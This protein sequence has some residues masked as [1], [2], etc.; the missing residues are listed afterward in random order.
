MGAT[1]DY[2][3]SIAKKALLTAGNILKDWKAPLYTKWKGRIDPVTIAD[4][5]SEKHIVDILKKEFPN[6]LII[7]EEY[8]PLKEIEVKGKRRWYL[9]PL[10]GT[11]NFFRG[12][13]NWCI[14][15]ALADENDKIVCA[16]VNDPTMNEC[17]TA[18]K[19]NGAYL[20]D[21]KINVS[22]IT[23]LKRSVVASGFPYTFDNPD[24]T[25]LREW[26]NLVPLVLT[27]RS[28]GAAA[29]DICQVAVGRIDVFW[30]RGLERWD[31]AA[32]ILICTESGAKVT[33][34]QGKIF[35]GPGTNIV[36]ANEVLHDKVF[37]VLK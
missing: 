19:G 32:G 4:K 24:E 7:S 21:E 14:S 10:D 26:S 27:A 17:Y 1:Y 2:E 18:I 12:L 23:E 29:K 36:I 28:L 8:S 16:V 9:D 5:T 25:N 11:V 37:D 35:D 13:P 33:N 15:L 6:D 20:N 22:D 3:L 34:L 31:T 30:E